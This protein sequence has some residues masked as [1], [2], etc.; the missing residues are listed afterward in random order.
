MSFVNELCL[1]CFNHDAGDP[2]TAPPPFNLWVSATLSLRLRGAISTQLRIASRILHGK[3]H[4]RG[5]T[6]LILGLC[7]TSTPS[8]SDATLFIGSL[9]VQSFLPFPRTSNRWG[10]LYW[11]VK[12]Y[13]RHGGFPAFGSLGP[14]IDKWSFWWTT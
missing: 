12:A 13:T 14:S 4:S 6:L 5:P 8:F 9:V 1:H 3:H 11:H 2:P 10:V 7:E